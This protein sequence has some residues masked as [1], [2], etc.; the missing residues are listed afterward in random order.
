[1]A[2]QSNG[3]R[4]RLDADIEE[5]V[6]QKCFDDRVKLNRVCNDLLRDW[7]GGRVKIEGKGAGSIAAGDESLVKQLHC[8]R[9]WNSAVW[10]SIR[11]LIDGLSRGI[12]AEKN[13]RDRAAAVAGGHQLASRIFGQLGKTDP[14]TERDSLGPAAA[15][16][17]E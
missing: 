14:G 11:G 1:M 3:T 9:E 10:Q 15:A 4:L 2:K 7:L 12:D 5:L 6:R 13:E 17:G 8:I 16:G